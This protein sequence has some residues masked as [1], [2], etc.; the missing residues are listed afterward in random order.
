M[1]EKKENIMKDKKLIKNLKISCEN[2]KRVL[3]STWRTVL[4]I[5]NFYNG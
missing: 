1:G 4:S 5:P 3:S 2:I